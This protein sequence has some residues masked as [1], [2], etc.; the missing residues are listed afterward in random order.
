MEVLKYKI[1]DKHYNVYVV[2]YKGQS[3]N[4]GDAS[5][6]EL[7]QEMIECEKYVETEI[8]DVNGCKLTTLQVLDENIHCFLGDVNNYPNPCEQDVI[9]NVEFILDEI[10]E[11]C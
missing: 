5:L 8:F 3:F 1:E 7:I 9:D 6:N 10:L 2:N 11:L 4:I